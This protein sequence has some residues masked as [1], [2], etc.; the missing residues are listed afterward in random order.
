MKRLIAGLAAAAALGLAGSACADIRCWYGPDGHEYCVYDPGYYD[1][2]MDTS[3]KP[4]ERQEDYDA[5][6]RQRRIDDIRTRA[7]DGDQNAKDIL[8]LLDSRQ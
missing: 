6:W 7:N 2:G 5:F 1:P 3:R 4:D 8:L